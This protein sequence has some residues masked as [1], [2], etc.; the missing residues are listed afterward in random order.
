MVAI[1]LATKIGDCI[2]LKGWKKMLEK[3]YG[4][5]CSEYSFNCIECEVWRLYD[6]IKA[7]VDMD[8]MFADPCHDKKA[9]KKYQKSLK[10][11]KK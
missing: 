11:N 10:K 3:H 9:E 2:D 1:T 7:F 6:Q 8:S 4:K 5:R